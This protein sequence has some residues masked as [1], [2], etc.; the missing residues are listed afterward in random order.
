MNDDQKRVAI[1]LGI[2]GL[3][4]WWL[5]VPK[6]KVDI[7]IIPGHVVPDGYDHVEEQS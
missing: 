4:A 6:G 1:A 2:V 5:H 7:V 3:V